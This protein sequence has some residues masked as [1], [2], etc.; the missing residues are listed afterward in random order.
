MNPGSH[1]YWAL[2]ITY[3]HTMWSFF[4]VLVEGDHTGHH[5]LATSAPKFPTTIDLL[6]GGLIIMSRPAVHRRL[7]LLLLLISRRVGDSVRS[8]E[9]FFFD[10]VGYKP[11]VR[12]RESGSR[13]ATLF[14]KS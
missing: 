3:P 10:G 2:F 12:N 4:G 9:R 13:D 6:N 5:W 11:I 14:R 1:L 8:P 7:L